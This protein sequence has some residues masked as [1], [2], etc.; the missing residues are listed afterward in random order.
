MA[1]ASAWAFYQEAVRRVTKA[2][3]AEPSLPV[4]VAALCAIAEMTPLHLERAFHLCHGVSMAEYAR[5]EWESRRTR[6]MARPWLIAA[7]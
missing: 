2:I 7:I 6:G 4:D 5:H 3:C 1:S